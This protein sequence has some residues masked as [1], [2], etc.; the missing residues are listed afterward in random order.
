MTGENVYNTTSNQMAKQAM[1]TLLCCL[2]V[3]RDN[4]MTGRTP[5]LNL[6]STEEE[7]NQQQ[8]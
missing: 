2:N 1:M 8:Q 4:S 3:A 7:E 6:S 5:H